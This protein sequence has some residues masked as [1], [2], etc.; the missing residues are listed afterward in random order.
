[1][2]NKELLL[3]TKAKPHDVHMRLT[4]GYWEPGKEYGYSTYIYNTG[5][6]DRIPKWFT[7]DGSTLQEIKIFTSKAAYKT[8]ITLKEE[9]KIPRALT[10]TIIEKNLTIP[11]QPH[12]EWDWFLLNNEIQAFDESDLGKTFS[13]SFD[14]PPDGYV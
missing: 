13:I 1:M 11:L 2:L 4:V 12:Q 9:T 5:A 8:S 14:P 3:C 10:V 6:A 7:Q